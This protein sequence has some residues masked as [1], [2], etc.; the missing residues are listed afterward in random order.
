MQFHTKTRASAAIPTASLPDIIF[1]LL[2]FFMVVTVF[3]EFRGL[4]IAIPA[5]RTTEKLET[6]RNVA[7][8]WVDKQGRISV[9]DKIV[10]MDDVS[11][12]MADKFSQNR[13]LIISL[14]IDKDVE[15]GMVNDLQEKLRD[16]YTLRVNYATRFK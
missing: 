11:P 7:Y 1:M 12:I 2:I 9:D 5:A 6:K 13:R 15:M 8:L 14:K 4:P 16:A 10:S 3:K